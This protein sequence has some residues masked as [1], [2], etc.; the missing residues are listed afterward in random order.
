MKQS[1]KLH[2][3]FMNLGFGAYLT[4]FCMVAQTNYW[5]QFYSNT[6][7]TVL[8]MTFNV[9]AL[10]GSLVALPLDKKFQPSFFA[11][12]H[13]PVSI[14]S[15]ICLVPIKYIQNSVLR[16]VLT[17]VPIACSG[18]TA[19]M[20]YPCIIAC[21]AKIDPI[22]SSTLQVAVGLSSIIIQVIEDLISA[23]YSNFSSQEE[24]ERSLVLNAVYYYIAG[25]IVLVLSYFS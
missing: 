8:S 12:L 18:F 22:L 25:S 17:C 6:F 24:Y 19:S 16:N 20:S 5:R 14:V 11:H 1:T 21:A 15:L 2:L 3:I 13:Y 10:V 23:Y 9:A 7:L 4:F